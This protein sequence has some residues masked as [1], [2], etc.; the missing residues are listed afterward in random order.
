[1]T[2]T[3]ADERLDAMFAALADRTRR[4][5][6]AR[7]S[8]GEATVNELAAPY[9]MSLQAVSQ[10]IG[11]LERCGLVSRGRHRQTRPCRLEPQALEAAVSWIE[12]S[13]RAW[14]E[15]MDRLEVHLARLQDGSQP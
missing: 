14:V 10:H 12:E 6:V 7:L 11:V 3:P 8:K 9:P 2:I 1:M 13:R 5:I 4:D 15:R